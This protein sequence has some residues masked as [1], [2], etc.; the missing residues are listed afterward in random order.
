MAIET[1]L[2]IRHSS[3]LPSAINELASAAIPHRHSHRRL[4]L[5]I[6]RVSL[7]LLIYDTDRQM[8][9][10]KY[11]IYKSATVDVYTNRVDALN[12][13]ATFGDYRYFTLA[14]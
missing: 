3:L 5:V 7:S 4:F 13:G 11:S 12:S 9:S 2:D 10:D 1:R 6:V 14:E 8:D